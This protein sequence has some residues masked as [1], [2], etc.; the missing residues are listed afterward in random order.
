MLDDD[1]SSRSRS[2]SRSRYSV[3]RPNPTPHLEIPQEV[4]FAERCRFYTH[5]SPEPWG[6]VT[7]DK[8]K[9]QANSAAA[10]HRAG[11]G[12]SAGSSSATPSAAH[13][14]PRPSAVPSAAA[15]N[16]YIKEEHE[17]RLHLVQEQ[18]KQV[19][20]L[21]EGPNGVVALVDHLL[22]LLRTLLAL[23]AQQ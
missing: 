8:W 3:K 14:A 23:V 10:A 5:T 12:G 13:A 9:P 11:L 20:A 18:H 19:A 17:R 6:P 2:R 4:L 7:G 21:I 16:T 22:E 15:F 1:L